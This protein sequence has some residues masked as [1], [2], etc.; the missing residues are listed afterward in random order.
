MRR[1][2]EFE[3]GALEIRIRLLRGMHLQISICITPN[4]EMIR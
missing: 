4:I 2:E 3:P 1:N